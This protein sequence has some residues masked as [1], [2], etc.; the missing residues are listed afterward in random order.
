MLRDRF[1]TDEFIDL[2]RAEGRS[3]EQERRLEALKRELAER[4]M[5]ES[6]AAVLDVDDQTP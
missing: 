3:A 4:V 2:A 6:A 5:S 1:V